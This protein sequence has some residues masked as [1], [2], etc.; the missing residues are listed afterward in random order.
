[1]K[2]CLLMLLLLVVSAF[3]IVSCEM[4]DENS[5]TENPTGG[6]VKYTQVMFQPM[7]SKTKRVSQTNSTTP[8][9]YRYKAEPLF[10][11]NDSQIEYGDTDG[12]EDL[13][14][15]VDNDYYSSANRFV[16]GRWLFTLEALVG[17]SVLYSG[18]VTVVLNTQTQV[19]S[20]DLNVC[21]DSQKYGTVNLNV[22]APVLSENPTGVF[23]AN[24]FNAEYQ[25]LTS[26]SSISVT[27]DFSS[28]SVVV[29]T[30][31]A[32]LPEGMYILELSY[33]DSGAG[34]G[35]CQTAFIVKEAMTCIISGSVDNSEYVTPSL[36]LNY[37]SGSITRSVV[38]TDGK[39]TYTF[40]PDGGVDPTSCIWFVNGTRQSSSTTQMQWDTSTGGIYY[41]TCIA[42]RKV[43]SE[44]VDVFSTTKTETR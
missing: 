1:M 2:K 20:I 16:Q 40:I 6:G 7:Y 14:K 35:P 32:V 8:T 33:N 24:L 21:F 5:D 3:I 34:V 23:T 15:N 13:T 36:C 41:I 30:G 43:G 12:F 19:V 31:S 37:L 26:P 42:L 28:Q 39:Y 9:S 44:V 38:K 22:R 27:P 29:G 10:E 11:K 17:D 25:A 4:E 18:S